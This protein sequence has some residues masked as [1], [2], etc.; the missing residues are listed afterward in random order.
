ML[1]DLLIFEPFAMKTTPNFCVAFEQ[2]I[3]MNFKHVS[4]LISRRSNPNSNRVI[5]E[6]RCNY[7]IKQSHIPH[8]PSKMDCTVRRAVSVWIWFITPQMRC[9]FSRLALSLPGVVQF[10]WELIVI[11]DEVYCGPMR[12]YCNHFSSPRCQISSKLLNHPVD[13]AFCLCH[14]FEINGFRVFHCVLRWW[15]DAVH[16]YG[17]QL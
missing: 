4:Q 12:P 9:F 6:I 3:F 7:S 1:F 5:N 8:K 17:G 13:Y 16:S 15:F 14:R 10:V 2:K 11:N